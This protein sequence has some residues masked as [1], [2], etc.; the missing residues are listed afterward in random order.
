MIQIGL[1]RVNRELEIDRFL[2]TQMKIRIIMKV[3]FTKIERF[4]ISKNRRFVIDS[5]ESEN[6]KASK[7]RNKTEENENLG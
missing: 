2:K 5:E 4:L 3:M 1:D 7:R 6:F